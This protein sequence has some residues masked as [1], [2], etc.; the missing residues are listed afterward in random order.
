MQPTCSRPAVLIKSLASVALLTALVAAPA[1]SADRIKQSGAAQKRVQMKCP[2]RFTAKCNK[3]QRV[4]CIQ[5][6][7][8]GCCTKSICQ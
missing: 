7:S 4:V 5:N 2:P 3:Y 6:D 1:A 8:R